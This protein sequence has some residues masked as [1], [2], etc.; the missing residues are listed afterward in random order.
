MPRLQIALRAH[1]VVDIVQVCFEFLA[2][3]N[4][5]TAKARDQSGFLHV[6]HRVAQFAI[7]EDLVAFKLHF[8]DAHALPFVNH[9]GHGNRCLRNGI[10]AS[11]DSGIRVALRGEQLFDDADGITN[12]DR[13]VDALFRNTD[14]LFAKRF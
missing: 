6:F 1:V 8:D 11:F 7:A 14:A 5:L 12:F 10:F 2:I 4:V 3:E 9:K 13:I